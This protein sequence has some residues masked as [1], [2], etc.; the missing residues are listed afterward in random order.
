M[1]PV[2]PSDEPDRPAGYSYAAVLVRT[3]REDLR[4]H[5]AEV[6]FS[7]FLG[8]Q[9]GDWVVAVAR[10]SAGRVARGRRDIAG[11]GKDV[12]Q[13][14]DTAALTVS[15]RHDRVLRLS[16]ADGA[17]PVIAYVSDPSYEASEEEE[18]DVFPEP[19]GAEHAEG[20]ARLCGRPEVAEELADVL[21]QVLDEE[22]DI[23]SERL[24]AVLR[25]LGLPR[26]VVAAPALPKDVP[27]GPRRGEFVRLG[28][29]REG[30]A[31]RVTGWLSGTGRRERRR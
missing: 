7:G 28:A 4:R 13:R 15:V 8:P 12:A 30:A 23:E 14:F 10:R 16:A 2:Y 22:T 29:G 24:T 5:L 18:Q 3:R 1:H 11:V 21:G 9:E 26:W 27:G 20:L 25:L 6:G 31:G 19:Q 17:R